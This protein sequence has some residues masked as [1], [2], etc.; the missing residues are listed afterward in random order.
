M[1]VSLL[2]T[3][4][5]SARAVSCQ[6]FCVPLGCGEWEAIEYD[7][8]AW[9]SARAATADF[10]L[11]QETRVSDEEPQGKVVMHWLPSEGPGA[12][13]WAYVDGKVIRRDGVDALTIFDVGDDSEE[14]NSSG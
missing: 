12:G 3:R 9:Y 2:L 10:V 8:L 4:R 11:G 1:A 7:Q 13:V 5:D 6:W 14:E